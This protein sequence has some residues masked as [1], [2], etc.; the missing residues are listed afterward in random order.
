MGEPRSVLALA[1]ELGVSS[2]PRALPGVLLAVALAQEQL[3]QRDAAL[4]TLEKVSPDC[5]GCRFPGTRGY[6]DGRLGLRDRAQQV[7]GELEARSRTR[8]VSGVDVAV[9]AAGLG[10]TEKALEALERAF[11]QRSPS[12][13]WWIG[14]P[15][16][17]SL[18]GH[19]RF[20][21]LTRRL[22]LPASEGAARP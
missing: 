22:G 19:P 13:V 10:D 16:F 14:Y 17:D 18:R 9:I 12:L 1:A 21:A 15:C 6:L 20:Q 8:F 3:G 7:L 2:K 4:L 11:D 5:G